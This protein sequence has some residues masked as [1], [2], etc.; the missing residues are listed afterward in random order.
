MVRT[1][2]VSTEIKRYIV[3][4][5]NETRRHG[6][7]YLGASPRGSLTLFRTAQA[8]AA[9]SGRD[10]AVP[11]DVKAMAEAALVHRLIL[12]PAAR[13]R[14]VES[15]QIVNEI[16]SAVPVPGGEIVS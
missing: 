6:E 12:G 8:R 3:D 7:V 4:L 1:V 16:V 2:S 10:Y 15:R 14:E 5:V 11:D 9:I 13:I